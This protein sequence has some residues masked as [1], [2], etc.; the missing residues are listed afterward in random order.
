MNEHELRAL[1]PATG[2]SWRTNFEEVSVASGDGFQAGYFAHTV[3]SGPNGYLLL[4]EEEVP[5]GPFW[6][7]FLEGWNDLFYE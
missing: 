4:K 6:E 2:K 3:Y 7:G 1:I 5:E